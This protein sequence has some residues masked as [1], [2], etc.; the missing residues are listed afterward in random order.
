MQS[1]ACQ[2]RISR[3]C[4]CIAHKTEGNRPVHQHPPTRAR[5][6]Q[7]RVPAARLYSGWSVGAYNGQLL[8]SDGCPRRTAW[9]GNRAIRPRPYAF[10]AIARACALNAK[11]L[12]MHTQS[13][14]EDG[15]EGMREM[16]GGLEILAYVPSIM[17]TSAHLLNPWAP[18]VP[19]T[20]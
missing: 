17:R 3:T 20:G 2:P 9:A 8:R 10:R 11:R 6:A 1:K 18:A 19:S 7:L 15:R 16:I 5:T 13:F 12:P 4:A 14:D